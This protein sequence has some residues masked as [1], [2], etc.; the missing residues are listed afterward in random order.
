MPLR[1]TDIP[2]PGSSVLPA[3]CQRSGL[4][5]PSHQRLIAA[6]CAHRLSHDASAL[7]RDPTSLPHRRAHATLDASAS[8]IAL[9]LLPHGSC[10]VVGLPCARI[11]ESAWGRN[12]YRSQVF[13][14]SCIH[15][16]S[17]LSRWFPWVQVIFI[18]RRKA[19]IVVR[20]EQPARNYS[21]LCSLSHEG[22]DT[23]AAVL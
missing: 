1:D 5:D 23:W 19:L 15:H 6:R 13:F 8:A 4:Y 22:V 16:R 9:P 7:P 12:D 3:A 21:H 14:P 17:P 20:S 11:P 18:P 2:I 10:P